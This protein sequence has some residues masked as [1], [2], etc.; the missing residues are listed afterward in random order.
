MGMIITASANHTLDALLELVCLRIQLSATQD[1]KARRHYDAVADWLSREGSPLRR[2][3]PHIF[4]QGSQRL[5]TTTKPVEQ[6]EFDLDAICKLTTVSSVHP[7]QLYRLLWER[8]AANEIYRPMLHRLRRCVRLVYAGDFHLD[9]APAIPDS[10]FGGRVIL[11]PDLHANLA[12]EHPRNDQ[13]KSTNPQDYADWFEDRC[14]P[15]M[16]WN[17]KYARA[18]VDPV[19]ESEPIHAKP[20]LKRSVQLFKRWRDVEYADRLQLA[21]PSI[22]LTT[23]SGHFYRGQQLCTDALDSILKATVH[24]IESCDRICLTNPAHPSENICEKWDSEPKSYRDFTDSVTKFRNCWQRLQRL[25]GLQQIEAELSEL[26]G[27]SPV[28]WAIGE[29][30]QR[31]VIQPRENKS[32]RVQPRS[33][34]LLVPA[35]V[36]SGALS[37]P[38]NTFHGDY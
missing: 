5:G 35:A 13:W 21:P 17:E 36:T 23:L 29:L 18:Q 27:E 28:R 19:P 34:G 30:A 7:G 11:V 15:V 6:A 3:D 31:Q 10:A 1:Q 2:F 25:R 32:L 33:S 9:I 38:T 4:S 16:T 24:E 8:L 22:I 14:L 12:L 20:A 26:F 37:V